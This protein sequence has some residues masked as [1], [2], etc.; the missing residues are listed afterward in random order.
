MGPFGSQ[1]S[2]A[3]ERIKFYLIWRAKF[4]DKKAWRIF[5][6]R[7][8]GSSQKCFHSH[9]SP[10]SQDFICSQNSIVWMLWNSKKTFLFNFHFLGHLWC[11]KMGDTCWFQA[12][13]IHWI[14][15]EVYELLQICTILI[16]NLQK[17]V[18]KSPLWGTWKEIKR[19]HGVPALSPQ[20]LSGIRL[21]KIF[22]AGKQE[23]KD[24]PLEP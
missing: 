17:F 22:I 23:I 12:R 18:V 1:G 8:Y 15:A 13:N 9:T 16:E 21:V 4:E 7:F 6:T 24:Q 5:W 2:I 10:F 3:H 14:P 20:W 11:T 19:T